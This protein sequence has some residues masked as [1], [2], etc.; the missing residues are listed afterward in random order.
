MIDLEKLEREVPVTGS[1]RRAEE[2]SWINPRL[3]RAKDALEKIRLTMKDVEEADARLRR[4]APF[5]AKAFPGTEPAG[6]IIESPLREIPRM[7]EALNRAH[8]ARLQGRL[9]LKMDSELAVAGSVKARGG[10]YEIL[11][12]AENLALQE[13]MIREGENYE[14][15][16]EPRMR[17]F[18]SNY[19]VHVGSTGNLGLSIGIIS[20]AL[21]FRVSVHMSQDAKQWKKDLLRSKGVRVVEYG[22]DY[23]EAVKNGRAEAQKDPKGYFVDDE[24][25]V[26]LFL[27][28]A[29][30]ALRLCRQLEEAD[31]PVDA[32]HPLFVSIP[33]GVGGAPG[34]ITFGLKLVYG[35]S[36]HV[37]YA[38]PVQ[39]CCMLLGIA[40][41]LHDGI[42]VQDIGLT[43]VTEADG[44][45]VGRPSKF[46]GKTVEHLLSGEFTVEDDALYTYMKELLDTEGFFIEPSSCAAFTGPE[47]IE[48]EEA[49]RAYMEAHGL[50]DRMGQASHIVWATGGS[51]VP[52][53]VR[54]ELL[55]RA[56]E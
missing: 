32:E 22:G 2:V 12:H 19:A 1:L 46:V 14:A 30:A 8:G 48:R 17:A 24:N 15:F 27:G 26:S 55:G 6:G 44:L 11:E 34:G 4:F 38:E 9:L 33:C 50:A 43:G 3:E 23:G 28:Y 47:R 21:G 45:A 54:E 37:F 18:F 31:V 29:V 25:S 13:G 16:A 5:I 35:D 56:P 10:I 51:L 41:G 42:C 36:V 39:A 53:S 7:K 52:Q 20:A 40:T 49:C